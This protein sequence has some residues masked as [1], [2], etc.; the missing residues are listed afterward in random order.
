MSFQILWYSYKS[1]S[2]LEEK[3]KKVQERNDKRL[4]QKSRNFKGQVELSSFQSASEEIWFLKRKRK[5]AKCS[6]KKLLS[7]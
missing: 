2:K 1:L 4:V 7:N 5:T 3:I 6:F